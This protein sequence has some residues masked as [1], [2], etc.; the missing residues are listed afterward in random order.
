MKPKPS[1]KDKQRRQHESNGNDEK[2]DL[3][4][5]DCKSTFAWIHRKLSRHIQVEKV[6]KRQKS[7]GVTGDGIDRRKASARAPVDSL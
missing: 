6:S 3:K 7:V 2:G 5:E 1:K 4:V